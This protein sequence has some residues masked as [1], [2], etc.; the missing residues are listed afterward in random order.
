MWGTESGLWRRSSPNLTLVK[1]GFTEEG[2]TFRVDDISK[3]IIFRFRECH[4]DQE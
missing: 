1:K 4:V 3:V 2:V